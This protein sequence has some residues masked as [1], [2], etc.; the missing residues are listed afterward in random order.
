MRIHRDVSAAEDRG[1]SAAI[2][3]FDGVHLGHQAVLDVARAEARRLGA[4][5]GVVTFEP[6]PREHF[7]PDAP[8]F[9]LM[10]PAAR[11]S[12]LER[13][14]VDVLHELPF[15]D[16]MAGL[17]AEAFVAEVLADGLGLAHA[18]VGRDFRFGR[19]RAGDPE[20]LARLGGTRGIGVSVAPMVSLDAGEVS[21]TRIREALSD[22]RPQEA[23]RMLGHMHRVEGPVL[24]GEK[25][26]RGLGYPTANLDLGGLHLP[27]FGVYAVRADV[28]GSRHRGT[29]DGAASLGTRPMFGENRPNLETH[30]L[31]FEGDLYGARLSVGL[32]EFLRPEATFPTMEA[33]VAQ[34][35][36]DCE[37][38]RALLSGPPPARAARP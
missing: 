19:G 6:H 35:A 8:P 32:F 17:T 36:D 20:A 28:L 38:A 7:A 5:L 34:M 9:R 11:A 1:A 10:S 29:Y 30:L 26:G 37:R 31:D 4:P 18:V 2:G 16:W 27:R 23:A 15:D 21:S 12:R 25:R 3:N 14:G 22:G 13:L 24:H 33:F